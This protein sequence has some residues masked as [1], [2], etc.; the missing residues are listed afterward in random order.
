MRDT[1]IAATGQSGLIVRHRLIEALPYFLRA[2]PDW[3]EQH[4]IGALLE[5]STDA[6][7][8]WRAV[9]RRPQFIDVP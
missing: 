9:A 8:L 6:L 2:D 3:A 4:L 1:V 7:S 5:D